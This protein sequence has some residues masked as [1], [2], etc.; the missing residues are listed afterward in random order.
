[1]KIKKLIAIT[2]SGILAAACFS[3]CGKT[4]ET[5]SNG[6]AV[7]LNGDKIYPIQ[8]D[9]TLDFWFAG[10]TGWTNLYE[11]FGDTPLAKEV[12]KKTGVKINYVHP[13]AGQQNEQFQL[14]VASDELPDIV[15]HMWFS[16]PGGPDAAIKDGYIYALNDI[17]DEYAPALKKVLSE[18]ENWDNQVKTD[19][20]DYFI[21]PSFN[22]GGILRVAYGPVLRAD[23]ME[24]LNLEKPTT[25]DEWENVLTKFKEVDTVEF[26]MTA[27]AGIL[28]QA[29]MPAFGTYPGW[30]KDDDEIKYGQAQPQYKEF[31]EK[32]HDWY[33]KGLI[34]PDF[35][36]ADGKTI[37]KAMLNHQAGA[38]L[39]WAGSGVGV[40]LDAMEGKPFDIQGVQFPSMGDGG[41]AEY[42]YLSSDVGTTNVNAISKRCK[43]VELA[44]RF[45]DWGFTE[46]GYKIYNFGVEGESF[47]YVEKDGEQYPQMTDLILNNPDGIDVATMF[48]SY[49]RSCNTCVPMVQ[50]VEYIEQF[51]KRK[52]QKDAQVEWAKQ[53]MDSH[54]IPQIYIREDQTDRDADIMA[55]I[56]TYVEEMRVKFIDGR[57]P[58][59]NFD[60]Y[61]EQL[62]A[63]GLDESIAFRQEAYERAKNR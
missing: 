38:T 3:G 36:V 15:N 61:L 57:E 11:N 55:N 12:A 30:Y 46:E 2:M 37:E 13:Q 51:Y 1:M 32:M 60:K 48:A 33:K 49:T 35:A 16:Y 29:F 39:A 58:I 44:A 10:T 9:D 34:D 63:F 20:G 8:C 40:W 47:N 62:K 22:E 7:K 41:N 23:W 27:T 53:N 21:F 24:K 19:N 59:E 6:S 54:L 5:I 25:I 17:I 14:L 56:N 31:L 43:N 4:Q 50:A 42:G 45:L 52:Q 18:N 28:S 26:P